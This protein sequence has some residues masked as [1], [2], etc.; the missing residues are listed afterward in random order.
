MTGIDDIVGALAQGT[1]APTTATDI[2]YAYDA[3]GNK[4]LETVTQSAPSF[5]T[6]TQN[7]YFAYNDMNEEILADGA[8]NN[9]ASDMSNLTKD[10]GHILTYDLDGNRI[11]DTEVSW[12]QRGLTG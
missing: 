9:D 8:V 11:S 6:T 5:T 10:Q 4:M 1:I 2:T 7:L 12:P 3:V